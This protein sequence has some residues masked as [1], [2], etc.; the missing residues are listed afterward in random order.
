M[1]SQ[2]SALIR[3]VAVV[4]R[5]N[6]LV[7]HFGEDPIGELFP[8]VSI[9]HP[10]IVQGGEDFWPSLKAIP[11]EYA[12]DTRVRPRPARCLPCA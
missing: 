9:A 11:C 3:F 8:V 5:L 10:V 1:Y 7:G 2:S 4:R 12:P 6:V